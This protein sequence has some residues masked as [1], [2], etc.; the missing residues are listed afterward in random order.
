MNLFDIEAG[1]EIGILK[2]S[3]KEA[4]L[5]G[6]VKNNKKDVLVY[7]INKAKELNLKPIK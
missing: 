1:R 6:I 2:S 4:I 7:L 3:I 5:D